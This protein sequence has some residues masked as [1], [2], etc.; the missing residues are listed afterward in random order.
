MKFLEGAVKKAGACKCPESDQ[1]PEKRDWFVE[2]YKMATGRILKP[3]KASP[4]K[5]DTRRIIIPGQG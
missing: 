3:S 5:G 4:K 2:T 1:E